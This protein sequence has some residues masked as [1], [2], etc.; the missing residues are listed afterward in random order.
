MIRAVAPETDE[1]LGHGAGTP[2]GIGGAVVGM[3]VGARRRGIDE[4]LDELRQVH[5][6]DFRRA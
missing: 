1:A 4:P 5:A 6:D 3:M 2:T